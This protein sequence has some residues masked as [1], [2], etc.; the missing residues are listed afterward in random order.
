MMGKRSAILNYFEEG[1]NTK[2][3]YSCKLCK[4]KV[5]AGES[6]TSNL[7]H[8]IKQHHPQEHALINISQ[9]SQRTSILT[10]AHESEKPTSSSVSAEMFPIATS[11]A[12]STEYKK[13]RNKW[14]SLTE[15]IT[16]CIAKDAMPISTVERPGFLHI[17]KQ[18]D[19][20]YTP[21]SRK[22]MS[23][24]YLTKLYDVTRDKVLTKLNDVQHFASTTDM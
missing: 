4:I 10:K 18:F 16:F 21:P 20:R 19:Q 13:D 11:F 3:N 1:L 15:A 5:K 8:H 24:S 9:N 12:K 6:N 2:G 22:T 23:K 17:L 7:R 14:K